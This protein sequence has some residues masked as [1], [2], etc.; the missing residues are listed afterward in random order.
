M[1]IVRTDHTFRSAIGAQAMEHRMEVLSNNLA[2]ANT[3][4]FKRDVPVFEGFMV[5]ST[6]PDLSQGALRETGRKLDLGLSGPGFFEIETPFGP[7]Y[8]RNG[9]FTINNEGRLVTQDGYPVAGDTLIP[10]NTREI[11]VTGEGGV[12]ADGQR[13]GAVRVVEFGDVSTLEKQGYGLFVSRNPQA[14]A[15]ALETS[16]EQGTLEMSNVNV[17]DAMV[18]I[19]DTTRTY[20]AYQKMIQSF[21]ETDTKTVNDV[22]RLA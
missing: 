2:N 6:K 22:G 1:T 8:T 14:G 12:Y 11:A 4:G 18:K 7:R 9:N 13:A 17:V 19:I 15:S 16:V 3:P 21:E 20:E 5:N 10:A